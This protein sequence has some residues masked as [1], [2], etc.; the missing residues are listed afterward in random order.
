MVTEYNTSNQLSERQQELLLHA[1]Q[2]YIQ[3]IRPITSAPLASK[4][5]LSSAT[6]RNELARLEDIGYLIQPHTSSGRLPTEKAYRMLV[7]NL[8]ETGVETNN[9]R[10]MIAEL[11]NQVEHEINI[12]INSALTLVAELTGQLAWCN[13]TT[14]YNY[15]VKSLEIIELD[16]KRVMLA[17]SLTYS[18]IKTR[19][20]EV[21]T[22]PSRRIIQYIVDSF[23]SQF[24]G[25]SLHEIDFSLLSELFTEFKEYS[26]E[27][28]D[29]LAD[30]LNCVYLETGN[31]IN[32]TAAE[33]LLSQPEFQDASNK[34]VVILSSLSRSELPIT[35]RTVVQRTGTKTV[36][37]QI[38]SENPRPELR[39]TSLIFSDYQI[40]NRFAQIGIIGP[41]RMD[42][43][44]ILP[45]IA[46]TADCLTSLFD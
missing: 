34:A 32:F 6:V 31:T 19:A 13:F 12:L 25:K 21:H 16:S 33:K 17:L 5:S 2:S 41:L 3:S 28:I 18:K 44:F 43:R 15:I 30:F 38:G 27:L 23:N 10:D 46:A 36:A 45:I 42:Y 11:L 35:S 1:I 8:L 40:G 22:V 7:A 4:F 9:Q 26:E 37:A 39:D 24:A 29:K 20:I 14:N